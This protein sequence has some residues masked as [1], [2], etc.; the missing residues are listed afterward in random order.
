M[1]SYEVGEE[2]QPREAGL[3]A[4]RQGALG[5]ACGG[6][7]GARDCSV[8]RGIDR[9]KVEGLGLASELRGWS[10]RRG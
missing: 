6:A 7:I 2:Q 5:F 4:G 8:G 3:D 10:C 9:E 1:P